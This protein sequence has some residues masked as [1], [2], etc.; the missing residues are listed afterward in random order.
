MHLT[1]VILF[2]TL[3][4]IQKGLGYTNKCGI[5]QPMLLFLLPPF[6]NHCNNCFNICDRNKESDTTQHEQYAVKLF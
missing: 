1:L 2:T 4:G 3:L 6:L 5:F